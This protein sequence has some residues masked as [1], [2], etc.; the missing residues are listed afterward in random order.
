[1]SL[2]I[3][4]TVKRWLAAVMYEVY[5][6]KPLAGRISVHSIDE[7]LDVLQ[8]TEKSMVRFGDGEI[9]VINGRNIPTQ[10][11]SREIAEGLKRILAYSCEDLIVMLPDI[12]NGLDSYIP[13]T[14]DFWK[15]HL[16]FFRHV[17]HTYCNPDRIYYNSFVTRSYITRA[18]K[19]GSESIFRRFREVWKGRKV[20][21]VEGCTTHNGVGN[22]LL[23]SAESVERII[24][25]G[26]NAYYALDRILEEC[27]RYEKDR[28]FLLSVGITAK[29]LAEALFLQGYRVLDIGNL[30][31]EYEW[32]LHRA[33]EKEPIAKHQIMGEEADREA[34]YHQYLAEIVCRIE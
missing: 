34:G 27:L 12:F 33:M 32:Y 10:S 11:G 13:A 22:D 21:V 8:N 24:C 9:V 17:Y 29:F 14:Q 6:H 16:F 3:R 4:K 31:M 19:S 18:D 26:K 28:L 25:P 20:V 1:M 7:T 30:D 23:D 15:D 5:Q 2:Q